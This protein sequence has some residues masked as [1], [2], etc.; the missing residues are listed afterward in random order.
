MHFQSSIL[1]SVIAGSWRPKRLDYHG[2]W[3]TMRSAID[4]GATTCI[5]VIAA[6]INYSLV[7][8]VITECSVGLGPF[9][10]CRSCFDRSLSLYFI[11][12]RCCYFQHCFTGEELLLSIQ[13]LPTL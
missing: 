6:T 7:V 13:F 8:L 10:Y 9:D 12:L 1:T 3:V 11:R 4:A 2:K 5:I